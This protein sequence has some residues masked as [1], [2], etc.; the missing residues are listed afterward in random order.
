[1]EKDNKYYNIIEN[2]VKSNRK[3]NGYDAIIDDIIDDVYEHSKTVIETVRDENVIL[4]YLQ[5]IA[6]VSVITVPKRMNFHS[7]L[8]HRN[9]TNNEQTIIPAAGQ[10]DT[11]QKKENDITPVNEYPE[12]NEHKANVELV[13]KMINS[14]D[15]SSIAENDKTT[16]I[17]DLEGLLTEDEPAGFTV[18]ES[19]NTVAEEAGQTDD[20]NFEILE[21][22]N[23]ISQQSAEETEDDTESFE[24][25][26]DEVETM[27][28]VENVF[29]DD[30]TVTD[31]AILDEVETLEPVKNVYIEDDTVT[32]EANLDEVE[33]LKPVEDVFIEDD[34]LTDETVLD[35]VETLEPVEDVVE[36]DYS[37]T[38]DITSDEVETLEL[39][40]E[41]FEDN[42]EPV[43]FASDENFTFD[44]DE[45]L[46]I[47]STEYENIEPKLNDY[48]NNID[49]TLF[50]D[51]EINAEQGFGIEDSLTLE[52]TDE[53]PE[54]SYPEDK[55]QPVFKQVDYSLFDYVPEVH[56]DDADIQTLEDKLIELNEQ[57][58]GLN[59]LKIFD[60]KYKQNLPITEIAD[61][62]NIEKQ[63]VISAL[64]EIV[65]LI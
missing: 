1:M 56:N 20:N 51:N 18:E 64:D 54:E 22:N 37:D 53:N 45:D 8:N 23:E 6:S 11:L 55:A 7:E 4:S 41:S 40:P 65:D 61:K 25:T 29:I 2:L 3:Y 5:K 24:I 58:P 50:D 14:I 28:P 21:F 36:E 62:L 19:E 39:E 34:A 42:A 17:T 31:E 60:L 9:I 43:G 30:D 32:D 27:E 52:S 10:E 44:T 57:K 49:I 35:D 26:S 59:I 48:D 47:N 38:T 63:D 16:D 13:N 15:S 12:P 33:T 46:D